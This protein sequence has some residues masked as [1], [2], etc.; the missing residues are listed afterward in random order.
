[1]AGMDNKKEKEKAVCG[2]IPKRRAVL[3]VLPERETPGKMAIAW[4]M[5]IINAVRG[6]IISLSNFF[7][8]VVESKIK[9][10]RMKKYGRYSMVSK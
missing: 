9:L 2:T 8:K 10:L 6:V 7:L 4:A 5:P 3:T 1:M